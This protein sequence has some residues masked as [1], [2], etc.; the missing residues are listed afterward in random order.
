LIQII[1]HTQNIPGETIIWQ[2]LLEE[3][4]DSILV[5]KPGWQEADYEL[6]LAQA[7]PSCYPRLMIAEHAALCERFG[8]QG[9]HFGEAA[10]GNITEE[11]I[12]GY[13]QKGWTLSTSIHSAET[14]QVASNNW[15]NLLLSPVFDSISKKGY[16]A[17]F[18][19]NFRLDKDGF[20]GNVLA[21][22]GIN[23]T[24]A[25]KARNM[26]FDGIALLG[27]VWEKPEGAVKAFCRIRDIWRKIN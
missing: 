25:G 21:L 3:G 27:A 5:R 13:Q 9:L 7:D 1:T 24:T 8:L 22:G 10:R 19:E 11:D 26:Q 23:D 15:N 17:A 18:N 20:K 12:N 14:L 2:Q 6:L 16:P 4:A